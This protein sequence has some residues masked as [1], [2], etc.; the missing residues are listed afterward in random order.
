MESRFAKKK[1]QPSPATPCHP[2]VALALRS[3]G[4]CFTGQQDAIHVQLRSDSPASQLSSEIT[5]HHGEGP[6]RSFSHP[7]LISTLRVSTFC[8]EGKTQTLSVIQHLL[9]V[10]ICH[11]DFTR[12]KISDNMNSKHLYIYTD[13]SCSQ[14][15]SILLVFALHH[16]IHLQPRSHA[17][18]YAYPQ[19]LN[20]ISVAGKDN[21]HEQKDLTATT[22]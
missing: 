7:G 3:L 11:L 21:M 14:R 8:L 6:L 13:L 17:Q 18:Q 19:H 9:N 10:L 15:S 22:S 4:L 5:R 20:F 1:W 16:V 12:I 2:N